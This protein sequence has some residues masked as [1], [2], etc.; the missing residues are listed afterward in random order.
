[1][2]Y[3]ILS[4][5]FAIGCNQV[6]KYQ[7]EEDRLTP[8]YYNT[9]L[10][11]VKEEA[12][13][14]PKDED[15]IYRRLFLSQKLGWP[16]DV[17]AEIAF[18]INKRSFD[19]ELYNYATDFYRSDHQFERLLET[20]EKWNETNAVTDQDI[21]SKIIAMNGLNKDVEAS[22]LLWVLLQQ[23]DNPDNLTF[24][25]KRYLGLADTVRAAYALSKLARQDPHN[26]LLLDA[27]IP[28]LIERGYA[29]RAKEIL[30]VQSTDNNDFEKQFLLAKTMFELN[31]PYQAI[32]LLRNFNNPTSDLQT[33]RWYRD[34]NA[35]DSAHF[36]VDKVIARDSTREALFTKGTIYENRGWLNSAYSTFN[37]LVR[38]NPAD[39]ISLQRLQIVSRKIAYLRKIREAENAIPILEIPSLKSTDNE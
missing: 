28:F 4:F 25:A 16:D 26:S 7:I 15:L 9:L 11:E 22:R 35:W 20:V 6:T 17:S 24:I 23:N 39:S 13:E 8:D 3:L 31:E 18:L 5:I 34:L 10:S 1:M 21:R 33:A 2:R 12:T 14:N 30:L 37:L 19:Y 29:K 27:Y 32:D 36:Y 38:Q